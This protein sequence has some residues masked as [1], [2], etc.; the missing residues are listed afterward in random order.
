VWEALAEES[1]G[2]EKSY[3]M[4]KIENRIC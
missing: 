3:W 2:D 4:K 1:T